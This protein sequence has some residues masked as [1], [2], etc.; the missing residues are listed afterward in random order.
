MIHIAPAL[1]QHGPRSLAVDGVAKLV[2]AGR[3]GDARAEAA[4]DVKVRGDRCFEEYV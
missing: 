3:F 1:T 2:E 4:A